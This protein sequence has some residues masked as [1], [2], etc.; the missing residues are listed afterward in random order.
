M[1]DLHSINFIGLIF[2]IL[3]LALSFTSLRTTSSIGLI[4]LSLMT[5]VSYYI[6]NYFFLESNRPSVIIFLPLIFILLFVAPMTIFNTLTGFYGSS[7]TT[8]IALIFA[9]II[10]GVASTFDDSFKRSLAMGVGL[11]CITSIAYIIFSGALYETL[12]RFAFLAN[13]P[14]TLALYSLCSCFIVAHLYP[15]GILRLIFVAAAAFYGIISLSDSLFLALFCGSIAGLFCFFVKRGFFIASILIL[16]LIFALIII[17]LELNIVQFLSSLWSE[18]DEGGG[19][20]KLIMHGIEAYLASPIIG[21]GAGAFSGSYNAFG[22]FE[23]HNT[24]IDLL[25]IGGPIL[26]IIFILPLIFSIPLLYKKGDILSLMF[27]IAIMIF[28]FFH[29]TARHPII[30]IVWGLCTSQLIS[31]PRYKY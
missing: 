27:L 17:N 24:Y 29:F 10:G 13:N 26:P 16:L 14:N 4:E 21:H 1:K 31:K 3:S 15:K 22:R 2:G 23:A 20:I 6:L 8:L 18:A 9:S 12:L 11:S 7:I 28:T 25:T 19:R 5:V 30:W